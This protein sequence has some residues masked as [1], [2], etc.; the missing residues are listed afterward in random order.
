MGRF[1]NNACGILWWVWCLGATLRPYSFYFYECLN[2][3]GQSTQLDWHRMHR[4]FHHQ[5]TQSDPDARTFPPQDR[6]TWTGCS[7]APSRQ[8]FRACYALLSTRESRGTGLERGVAH[9]YRKRAA[10]TGEPFSW[11]S[12]R[13]GS[14]QR[15]SRCCSACKG[16]SL[17]GELRLAITSAQSQ[18]G[19]SKLHSTL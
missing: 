3:L 11:L 15:G 6:K 12:R 4:N 16:F 14:A 18:R 19:C 2:H 8:Q 7:A 5:T 9:Q 13:V 1:L 10:T 17:G